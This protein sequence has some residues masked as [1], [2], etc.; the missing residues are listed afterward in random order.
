MTRLAASVPALRDAFG[1][2]WSWPPISPLAPLVERGSAVAADP[3]HD[4]G[5][6]TSQRRS[7]SQLADSGRVW[8]FFLPGAFTPV[9]TAELGWVDELADRLA[10]SAGPDGAG[11]GL[12]ILSCDPVPVLRRVAEESGVRTPMLS[13]FWPH[14]AAAQAVGA[15]NAVTGVP[16]RTSVLVDAAGRILRRVEAAPGTERQ[17]GDH[18]R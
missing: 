18:L 4:A 9:C 11:V 8:L 13:D 17:L 5:P 3:G 10:D 7:A 1:Q 16:H 14:G 15:F 12:R 6:G 2:P